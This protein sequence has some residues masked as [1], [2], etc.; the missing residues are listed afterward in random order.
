MPEQAKPLKEVNFKVPNITA[1]MTS[2]QFQVL[3]DVIGHLILA[4]LPKSVHR[5]PLLFSSSALNFLEFWVE[6]LPKP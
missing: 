3:V 2:G 1:S 6:V 4:P 5:P